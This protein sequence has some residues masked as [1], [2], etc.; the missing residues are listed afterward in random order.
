MSNLSIWLKPIWLL[1][2][3]TTAGLVILIALW[4]I[5]FLVNR[6]AAAGVLSSI[7]EG[8]LLP[9]TYTLA[10]LGVLALLA[11]PT[12]NVSE[13]LD[14]LK[15]MTAVGQVEVT[16]TI[17]ANTP[18]FP[19]EISFRPEELQS[20]SFVSEQDLAVNTEKGKGYIEPVVQIE[21]NQLYIWSPGSSL[22]RSFEEEV[23]T[24]YFT[25]ETDL[26]SELTVIFTSDVAMPEVHYLR[27]AALSVVGLYLGYLLINLVAPKAAI[28]AA[29]TSKEAISQPLFMLLTVIGIAALLLYVYVPYNTFGE[30]VKMLKTS[31]MATIKVL[32]IIFALWTASVSVADEIEGRTALTV[33]SKPVSRRQFILGKFLGIVWPILLM[34]LILGTVFLL[35]VSY[36]VVYDARESAK[37]V[38]IWTECFAEVVR[39]VPGLVL[40]F[41]EAVVMA[42]ISVAISTRLSML[43]NL[44]IC[45]SIYVLGHLGPLIVKSSAGEIVFVKFIGR[46]ISIVLPV[47]DHYE[48]EGA[49]AG[50]SAVPTEYL[51]L[52]LIYSL[53]YCAAAM[54]LAL[55]FFEDRD[56]A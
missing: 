26:P 38:P 36:K 10:I 15:R 12:M 46:L 53:L 14:S 51:L 30:D 33:L 17:P 42:A 19:L 8:I 7:R 32:A 13:V 4:G 24:L 22:P 56:L 27:V 50:S 20:Y 49:I 39:I 55:L 25:N 45:G 2:L 21:G 28:I 16:A 34:F 9:V 44:I 18:D 29:A 35:T 54:L 1:S 52:A 3:G 5:L 31:G 43:P 47:L 6:R 23:E 41:F 40:A 11:T 48:I 37:T